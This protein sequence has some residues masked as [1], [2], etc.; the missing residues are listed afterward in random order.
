MVLDKLNKTE[1]KLRVLD[2]APGELAQRMYSKPW[3]GPF[4]GV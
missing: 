4:D 3:V 1:K 2:S